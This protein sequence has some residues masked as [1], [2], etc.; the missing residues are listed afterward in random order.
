MK[1]FKRLLLLAET[2]KLFSL[3]YE[4]M[5]DKGFILKIAHAYVCGFVGAFGLC[6]CVDIQKLLYD[7]RHLKPV[8][9]KA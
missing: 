2:I 7:L 8:S 1:H 5:M 3:R 9:Q 4:Q 6:A